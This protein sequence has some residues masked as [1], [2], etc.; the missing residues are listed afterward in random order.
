MPDGHCHSKWLC[1]HAALT[2]NPTFNLHSLAQR[3]SSLC[4]QMKKLFHSGFSFWISAWDYLSSRKTAV[5]H[6]RNVFEGVGL[7]VLIGL[8]L[9]VYM[10]V[11]GGMVAGDNPG[12]ISTFMS[13]LGSYHVMRWRILSLG[14]TT[15]HT[16][17]CCWD[18]STNVK[19]LQ[20]LEEA[21]SPPRLLPSWASLISTGKGQSP[22]W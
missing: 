18:R 10:W 12:L 13:Y 5:D 21:P 16:T 1:D 11:C 6:G 22:S 9:Y 7:C 3:L 19:F 14:R 15:L 20:I 4:Y 17:G 8:G 2:H